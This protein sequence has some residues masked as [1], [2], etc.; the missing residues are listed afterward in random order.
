MPKPLL[1]RG[2]RQLLTLH[3]P[4]GPRRG[5]ALRDLG[6]ILDG[7]LLVT[8]G[9]IAEVGPSR[10]VA[11]L[12]EAR[13]AEVID[14][15]GCVVMPG[16]VDSHT[17]LIHGPARAKE[18]EMRAAGASDERISQA[19]DGFAASVRAVRA[20]SSGQL[21]HAAQRHIANM[22]RHGTT[23]VEIKS[24][25]GLDEAAECK[26]LR[27]AGELDGQPLDVVPTYMGALAVPPEYA[28]RPDDYIEWICAHMLPKIER[29][30]L[31][32][33]ADV[34]CGNAGF[35]LAQAERY[36]LA[37]REHGLALKLHVE[38]FEHTGAAQLG[39][40]FGAASVDH[41][42]LATAEDA[43]CLAECATLATLLPGP[44]FYLGLDSYAPARLLIDAGAAV[45]LATDFN[46]GDSPSLSMP[47]ALSL[48]C[49]KMKMDPAEALSAATINGAHALQ[50]G[51]RAGSLECGKQADI[52]ILDV[53][54]YREIPYWFGVNPV[55]M[56]IKQGKVVY[57]R[58]A[59]DGGPSAG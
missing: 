10:R 54:D 44:V 8:G 49:L 52:V 57:R 35:T 39:A 50:I 24:G 51:H 41:L 31:A 37:A 28:E 36:L 22:A 4:S 48:A 56:T 7:S 53:P 2:A 19:G 6:L 16:F 12:A 45:A 30:K 11:N 34:Y 55:R 21:L 25:Y 14:A 29:R 40:R 17:H 33:F 42:L 26:V 3:G 47:M 59:V 23:T 9:V 1:I 18:F 15:T 58:G 38:M 13:G 43:R 5:A 46:P 27:L 20:S 32:R